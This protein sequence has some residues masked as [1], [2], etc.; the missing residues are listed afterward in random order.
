MAPSRFSL[1]RRAAS[2]H[3]IGRI[4]LPPAN[5]LY[6]IARWIDE[7]GAFSGG[8]RRLSPASITAWSVSKKSGSF[9]RKIQSQFSKAPRKQEIRRETL[10]RFIFRLERFRGYLSVRLLQK[11]FHAPLRFLEL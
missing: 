9:M 4:L 5:T 3:R 8:R 11:N 7:G 2:R 10:L 6:R 1:N